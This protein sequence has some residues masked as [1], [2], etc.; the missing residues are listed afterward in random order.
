MALTEEDITTLLQDWS[1]GD[2][3]ALGKLMPRV[4]GE[5]R[6]I[7]AHYFKGEPKDHTLQP[8]A[9]VNEVYVR[10][11]GRRTV[12]WESRAQF[13][14]FAAQTMRR[15]LVDHARGR[16]AGK[17]GYDVPKIS[18]EEHLVAV[19]R[20]VDLI[21]LD[22]ALEAL[23][24]I[25]PRQSRIVEMRFFAGLDNYE[26]AEVLGISRTTVKREWKTARVWLY[27]QIRGR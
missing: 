23:A 9:L 12:Q 25:D 1:D 24:K 27:E 13:F 18:L 16:K 2:T 15:L 6:E 17:R 10:L 26:I 22:D 5:L 20:A 21:A 11:V 4:Y 8:T 3:E 7:A 19:E 14:A